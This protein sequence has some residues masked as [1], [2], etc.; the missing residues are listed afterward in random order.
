VASMRFHLRPGVR[1]LF[2]VPPR[3]PVAA[4]RDVDDELE[5]LIASRVDYLVA[6]GMSPADAWNEALRRLGAPFDEARLQLHHSA[7][8]RERRMRFSEWIE[9]VMQD[10]HYAA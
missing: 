2:R 3:S 9:S 4:H 5:S 10:V 6:R 8:Y 7:E 1:R